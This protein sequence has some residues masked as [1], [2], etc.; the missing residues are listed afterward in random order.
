MIVYFT[1]LTILWDEF[2]IFQT[3]IVCKCS[4]PCYCGA[5]KQAQDSHDQDQ[6]I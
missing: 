3:I 2:E 4:I 1:Q 6:V 5:L